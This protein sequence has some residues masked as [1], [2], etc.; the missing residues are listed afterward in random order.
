MEQLNPRTT[1]FELKLREGLQAMA[2]AGVRVRTDG[3]LRIF[4]FVIR[5]LQRVPPHGPPFAVDGVF[6]LQIWSRGSALVSTEER[7]VTIGSS[8]GA[9]MPTLYFTF[10]D[11]RSVER[12]LSEFR[13]FVEVEARRFA[14]LE[15]RYPAIQREAAETDEHDPGLILPA[16]KLRS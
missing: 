3:G 4:S 5:R 16:R 13:A 10:D 9:L 2:V 11:R 14:E 7:D 8:Y 6:D 12:G 15:G 1:P